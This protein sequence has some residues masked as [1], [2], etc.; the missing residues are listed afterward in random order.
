MFDVLS[1]L[2]NENYLYENVNISSFSENFCARSEIN[3]VDDS[4]VDFIISD[5]N[6]HGILFVSD[7][8]VEMI[9]NYIDE[10]DEEDP[11]N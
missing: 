6:R 11:L 1:Y 8:N 3:F 5:K 9:T 2:K 7:N 4:K 10:F